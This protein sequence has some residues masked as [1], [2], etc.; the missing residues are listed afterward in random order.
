M[1]AGVVVLR[2]QRFD[3]S[4]DARMGGEG[5]GWWSPL[6]REDAESLGKTPRF[7]VQG[8]EM[9]SNMGNY[10]HH[11]P[12]ND[13][14]AVRRVGETHMKLRSMFSRG[15]PYMRGALWRRLSIMCNTRKEGETNGRS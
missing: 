6:R 2:W 4:N 13:R 11:S 12:L 7:Y 14:N 9:L 5:K 10:G 15:V 8:L 1:L 3:G